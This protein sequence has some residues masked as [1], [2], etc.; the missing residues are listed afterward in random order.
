[1]RSIIPA[2]LSYAVLR[3]FHAAAATTM[4]ATAS[5]HQELS[6]RGFRKLG[7]WDAAS[8]RAF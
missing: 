3:H 2:A 8:I 7:F 5:L 1:V 4:V 6:A